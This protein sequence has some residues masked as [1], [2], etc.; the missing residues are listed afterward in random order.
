V[1]TG[2]DI[3]RAARRYI[4]VKETPRGS[5]RQQFG[6]RYGMNGVAWCSIFVAEVLADVGID[7]RRLVTPGYASCEMA[8]AG[9]RAKHWTVPNSAAQPGDVVFYQFDRDRAADHTGII[10]SVTGG[11]LV[12]IEG[13]TGVGH[14]TNGGAV[15]ERQR[16]WSLVKGIGRI[17]GLGQ[18]PK[19]T[20]QPPSAPHPNPDAAPIPMVHLEDDMPG[21][22][23]KSNDGQVW[24]TNGLDIGPVPAATGA[25]LQAKV[26]ELLFLGLA[27]NQHDSAGNVVIP[28]NQRFIDDC[29]RRKAAA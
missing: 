17:P 6:A 12:A 18:P 29:R 16:S 21:Y 8:L 2:A 22:L 19:A 26:N 5:N 27:N 7:V 10:E 1:T 20:P 23:F 13:N 28:Q 14:D 9:F 15:M 25:E 24:L 11:H 4:G 3:V